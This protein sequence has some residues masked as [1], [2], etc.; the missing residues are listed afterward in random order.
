M[1]PLALT[2]NGTEMWRNSRPSSTGYCR[3][4]RLQFI[5]ENREAIKQEEIYIQ[6]QI[7]D[8]ISYKD[9]DLEIRYDL[10]ITMVDGK[11]VSALTNTSTQQCHI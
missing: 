3:P 1:V 10:F 6:K 9:S 5:H 4:I 7:V 2:G 11:D 8:L